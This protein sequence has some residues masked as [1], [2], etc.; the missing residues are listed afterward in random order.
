MVGMI[1]DALRNQHT[2]TS[3]GNDERIP[4]DPQKGPDEATAA[5]LKLL[6]NANTELYPG[7][8]NFTSLSFI[9]RLLHMKVL[10]KLSNKTIDKF[11]AFYHEAFPEALNLPNSYYEAQKITDD[12]GFTYKTWDV[13]PRS[14]MLFRNEHANLDACVVCGESRWKV[15]ITRSKTGK[16]RGKKRAAK[17]MRYIPLKSKLQRFFTSSETAKLMSWHA[18]GR[19]NDGVRRHPTDAPAWKEFD[20]RHVRFA[21][22]IRN[23]RLGLASDGFNPYGTMSI[24][25]STWPVVLVVYNLPPWLCMKQPFFILSLVIDGPKGPGDKI[26]VYLQPLIEELLELWNEGELTFDASTNQMFQMHAALMWTIN[27]FPAYANLSGWSTK[28]KFACPSCNKNTVS[29]WLKHGKKQSYRGHRRFLPSDHK[30]RKDRVSFDGTREWRSKPKPLS[31]SELLNQIESEGIL[32]QY[33]IFDLKVRFERLKAKESATSSDHN[34]KKKSIFFELPY[35]EFN[36]I[37]HNIDLMHGEKNFCDNILWTIL[38]IVGK[39]KDNP[40]ARRDLEFLNIRKSLHLQSRGSKKA[41]MPPAQFTMSKEEKKIFLKVLKEVRVPDGYASNISRRVRL[42]DT[43]IG[44][45]KSHDNH[46]LM[47]QLI[48]I[49]I[50]KALPKNVVEPL[51]ELGNCFRQL[52][53]K[54]NRASDLEYLEDR[55]VV[56]LCQ[57][58]KIFPPSFFDIMEHLAVHLAEEALIAGPVQFRWMYPF[59]RFLLTLKQYGRN[60]AHPEASIVKG[61]L[62][63]DCM[64]FCAQYLNDVETKLN[65]PARNY[66]GGDSMGRGVGENTIFHLDDREWIQA[67]RY[68]LFNTSSV[69]PFITYV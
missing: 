9:V 41:Y 4:N 37:R 39:S 61:Y 33:K 47:Q 34:W 32:T 25:H 58:E 65:R 67:H 53:S 23:I 56:T 36:L 40:S 13:C 8:K 27:D 38:G 63:E 22:D 14:C 60:K 49:A 29:C 45:L 3:V 68:I 50:R 55:F 57:L 5:Y 30:F 44:G 28:G 46:I 21:G 10:H 18:D 16:K 6:D 7:C 12:L 51:I 15:T 26:D 11:L 35:W 43:S 24:T 19:T 42:D 31:G 20:R 52:C 48:P 54:V 1:S 66:D 69:A 2:G 62:M 59:E 17:Q 64:N